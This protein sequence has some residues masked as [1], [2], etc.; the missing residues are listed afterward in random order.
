M[1]RLSPTAKTQTMNFIGLSFDHMHMGDLLREVAAHP[2]AR[3]AAL[4]DDNPNNA[5]VL[6]QFAR[7]L[8]VP[9]E[10]VFTDYA[11]CVAETG[12]D[13]AI[14]CPALSRHA[15]LC[16]LVANAGMHVLVEKPFAFSLSDA[17]RMIQ[18]TQNAGV[19]LAINWPTAWYAPYITCKRLI[20]EGTIGEVIEV[21]YNGG[22]RGPLHHG[23]GKAESSEEVR[24][25]KN[26]SWFYQKD[27]GG[28]SL[29][30]YMGY[31]ATLGTWF[32][33]G[34]KPLEICAMTYVPDG[35]EVEEHSLA[36]GN[37]GRGLSKWETRWG[38][39]TNPWT[40]Q[41]QPKTGYVLK[42]TAGTIAA[43]EYEGAMRV[44]TEAERGGFWVEADEVGA[45]YRG[46]IEHFV[47]HLRGEV[48]LHGPLTPEISRI[49]QQIVDSARQ[50]AAQ[51][52]TV[53]L[54]G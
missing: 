35:L 25:A 12:A 5:A 26:A 1:K 11:R 13:V 18:A 45:P 46:A 52:R 30:D 42:G 29:L 36:I 9:D 7:E 21:H 23:A 48:A 37:Y 47:A 54:L 10:R 53:E 4:C 49:G 44:Q 33:G 8:D 22:N 27:K 32:F 6:H 24:A 19:K 2:D 16:E 34:Q 41:P 28:G 17:D 15:E 14:L 50:S 39:F 51:G 38:T 20:D 31:G 43:Y 40:H 3:V